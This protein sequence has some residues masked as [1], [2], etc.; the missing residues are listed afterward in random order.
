MKALKKWIALLAAAALCLCLSPVAFALVSQSDSF[1]VADYANV[2]TESTEQT[3]INYNGALEQQCQGA[4]IVVVTVDYLEGMYSDEY[5]Y[6]LFNDWG[7]GSSEYNNG[8][9]L[10][11]STQENKAWLAYGL[12]LTSQIDSGE[13][14]DLLETYFWTDFDK[15]NYDSA[16]SKL[17]S[18]LLR[19]YDSVY[20]SQ[21]ASA[22][23]AA[24]GEA[25][26]YQQT[27][28]GQQSHYGSVL[29]LGRLIRILLI[30]IIFISL[31]SG[32]SGRRGGGSWLP[33]FLLFNSSARVAPAALA[34]AEGALAAA[35]A[36]AAVSAEA[37]AEASAAA[38]VMAAVDFPAAEAAADKYRSQKQIGEET[39]CLL[40]KGA[41]ISAVLVWKTVFRSLRFPLP[42]W[43]W[44]PRPSVWRAPGLQKPCPSKRRTA[45]C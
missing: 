6:Q 15:G 30:V 44:R 5:A 42:Q 18:A 43:N 11:L 17:F 8:M 45:A 13:V 1:Y 28:P 14:D 9:L 35:E 20:G 37:S 36:S 33:W 19:W 24:G 16:V 32:N 22:G 21:V 41:L 29:D 4:Q 3:I 23:S 40:K 34:A 2:L 12:G 25:V 27:Q 38:A 31:F 7:V 26:S 39:V 10:L